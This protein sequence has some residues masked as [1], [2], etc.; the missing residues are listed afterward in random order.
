[1]AEEFV[2]TYSIRAEAEDSAGKPLFKRGTLAGLE[3][4]SFAKKTYLPSANAVNE[5]VDIPAG[6]LLI[7]K[8][9]GSLVLQF[10]SSADAVVVVTT[11]AVIDRPFTTLDVTQINDAGAS[12]VEFTSLVKA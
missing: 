1:M 10:D 5:T 9:T 8:T 2:R 12:I 6:D 11:F 7:V 4:T 3:Y